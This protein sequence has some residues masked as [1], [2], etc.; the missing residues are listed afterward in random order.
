M[1]DHAGPRRCE[2][3]PRT[4]CWH[5]HVEVTQ[6]WHPRSGYGAMFCKAKI[7]YIDQEAG[8]KYETKVLGN[9]SSYCFVSYWWIYLCLVL[10]KRKRAPKLGYFE[11]RVPKFP[12]NP[13]NGVGGRRGLSY[14]LNHINTARF[15]INMKTILT[16]VYNSAVFKS[17][18]PKN[19]A[20]EKLIYFKKSRTIS[21]NR[22]NKRVFT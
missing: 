8:E 3:H 18:F 11:A 2:C 14:R 1:T 12:G 6:F 4:D 19:C 5:P 9:G 7:D 21:G 20:F 10:Q 22:W 17:I 16:S 15:Y 13:R